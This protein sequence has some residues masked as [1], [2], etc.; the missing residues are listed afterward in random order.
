M[1]LLFCVLTPV[2]EVKR[3]ADGYMYVLTAAMRYCLNSGANSVKLGNSSSVI[4]CVPAIPP[5]VVYHRLN[6][7]FPPAVIL[8]RSRLVS[9]SLVKL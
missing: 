1:T 5:S 4:E 2:P 9:I 7:P 6:G 8:P 3:L